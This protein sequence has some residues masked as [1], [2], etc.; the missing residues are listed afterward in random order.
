MLAVGDVRGTSVSNGPP[1]GDRR[2]EP[3]AAGGSGLGVGCAGLIAALLVGGLVTVVWPHVAGAPMAPSEAV[4]RIVFALL[5]GAV[6]TWL[7]VRAGLT[8]G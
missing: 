2:L 1:S 8:R 4:A 5:I 6:L 3:G 7:L